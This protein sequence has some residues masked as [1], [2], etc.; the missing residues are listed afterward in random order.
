MVRANIAPHVGRRQALVEEA[1]RGRA[2]CP[3]G[4]YAERR[5]HHPSQGAFTALAGILSQYHTHTIHTSSTVRTYTSR[6]GCVKL[7]DAMPKSAE[8]ASQTT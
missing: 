4:L 2:P 8:L 5:K 1:A 7:H 6:G 3:A